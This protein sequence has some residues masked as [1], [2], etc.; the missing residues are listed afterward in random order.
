MAVVSDIS[1]IYAEALTTQSLL[2]VAQATYIV[3]PDFA[4][5]MQCC[6]EGS[7]GLSK[8]GPSITLHSFEALLMNKSG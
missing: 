7:L 3:M 4:K 6:D 5:E 8:S 2:P 1:E